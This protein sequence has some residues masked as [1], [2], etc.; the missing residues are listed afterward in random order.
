MGMVNSQENFQNPSFKI[1]FHFCSNSKYN[2][3]FLPIQ[4]KIIEELLKFVFQGHSFFSI[5]NENRNKN[6]YSIQVVKS[7]LRVKNGNAPIERSLSDNKN[8]LLTPERALLSDET[9][10]G[11]R[12][13]KEVARNQK[14]P[15][16]IP[17][18][19]KEVVGAMKFAHSK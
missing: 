4:G 16:N 5:Q 12:R 11:L 10:V 6:Q 3:T 7:Y 18:A 15:H 14:G 17:T 8:T 2:T 9:L 1:D 19:T 13:M